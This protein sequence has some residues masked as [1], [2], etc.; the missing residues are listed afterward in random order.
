MKLTHFVK[1]D[2]CHKYTFVIFEAWV[3]LAEGK[4]NHQSISTDT[5]YV[6]GQQVR[7]S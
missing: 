7:I 6:L 3:H 1:Q 5:L 4:M 2:N